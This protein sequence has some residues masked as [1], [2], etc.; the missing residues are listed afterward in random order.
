MSV[1]TKLTVAAKPNTSLQ[2]QRGM[3][4]EV[5][6]MVSRDL[7]ISGKPTTGYESAKQRGQ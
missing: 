3:L 7:T 5:V 4:P 6:L 1:N 2:N